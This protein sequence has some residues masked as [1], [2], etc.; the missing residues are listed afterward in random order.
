MLFNFLNVEGRSSNKATILKLSE[1]QLTNSRVFHSCCELL[2]LSTLN[3]Y[4]NVTLAG[5][6]EIQV[7]GFPR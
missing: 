4:F 7:V 3:T 5:I 1:R 6:F 2:L